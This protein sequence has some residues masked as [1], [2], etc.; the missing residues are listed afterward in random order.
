[1]I[2][3]SNSVGLAVLVVPFGVFVSEG[4]SFRIDV[5]VLERP[6]RIDSRVG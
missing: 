1:M 4:Q 6:F 2:A 5:T 3:R